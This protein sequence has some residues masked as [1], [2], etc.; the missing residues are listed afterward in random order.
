MPTRISMD[1]RWSKCSGYYSE[2]HQQQQH[3]HPSLFEPAIICTPPLAHCPAPHMWTD[4]ERT[5]SPSELQHIWIITGPAGCGKTTLASLL[6]QKLG[7]PYIEGDEVGRWSR[8]FEL[9]R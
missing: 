5:P 7:L 9:G 6:A 8:F 1:A 3:H 2:Q 4:L